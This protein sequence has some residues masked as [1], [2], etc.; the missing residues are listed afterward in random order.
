MCSGMNNKF[1]KDFD[2]QRSCTFNMYNVADKHAISELP[3]CFKHWKRMKYVLKTLQSPFLDWQK[4][5]HHCRRFNVGTLIMLKQ[6]TVY[7][8]VLLFERWSQLNNS[9]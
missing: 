8:S 9:L 5:T 1:G 6:D 2:F 3:D 4:S 7:L